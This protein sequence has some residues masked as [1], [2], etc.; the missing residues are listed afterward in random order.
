MASKDDEVRAIA[1]TWCNMPSTLA[2]PE[3]IGEI[4]AIFYVYR[5]PPADERSEEYR[6]WK[7]Y[8]DHLP[9]GALSNDGEVVAAAEH[10]FFARSQVATGRYSST[11]MSAYI[12]LYQL[13]KSTGLDLRHNKDNPTTPPSGLQKTWALL[14]VSDGKQDLATAN[15]QRKA[16]NQPQLSPPIFRLPPNFTGSYGGKRLDEIK[17]GG[18]VK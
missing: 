5:N 16:A 18:S 2:P 4:A 15:E 7:A 12:H 10:Y 3:R 8:F 13:A 6:N 14:G 11:N 17:Y 1:T 9:A